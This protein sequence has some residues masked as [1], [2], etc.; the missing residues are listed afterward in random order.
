[1]KR[2][3]AL[4]L[5]LIMT[6][7]L[8]ACGGDKP[9]SSTP[10][11][12]PSNPTSSTP[13]TPDKP[14]EPEKPTEPDKP[15]EP[16]IAYRYQSNES[17]TIFPQ[18]SASSYDEYIIDKISA[19]LYG[20]L[21]VDGKAVLSPVLADGEPIDVNGDGKTW[22]IKVNK[23]AKWENGDPINADTF[24]FTF[25]IALDPK[26]YYTGGTAV[27]DN[28]IK[29]VNA[30]KYHTQGKEGATPVAW[31]E[32]GVK[33]I[34]EYTFQVQVENSVSVLDVMRHLNNKPLMPVHEGLYKKLTA[35]DGT[36]TYG[37]S[38]DTILSCGPYRLTEWVNEALHMFE[39]NEN[40]IRADLVKIDQ[41]KESI[42]K[43]ANTRLQMFENG[44]LDYYVLSTAAREK[45]EDDPRVIATPSRTTTVIE[46]MDQSTKNPI[47]G[48]LNFRMAMYYGLNREELSKLGNFAPNLSTISPTAGGLADGTLYK[49]YA[50]AN[51]TYLGQDKM[52]YDPELAKQYFD[53]ALQETGLKN[54]EVTFLVTE[55]GY[56]KMA[57]Y[58][59]AAWPKMFGEDKI[60]V[61]VDIQTTGV[62]TEIRNTWK[63]NPSAYD[64]CFTG[65]G[66]AIADFNPAVSSRYFNTMQAKRNAPH[67]NDEADAFFVASTSAATPE[68]KYRLAVEY[69]KALQKTM[70]AI[71]V[72][73]GSS[74]CIFS[75]RYVSPIDPENYDINGGWCHMYAD[76]IQ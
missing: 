53:K 27:A 4:I 50:W 31:E 23:N 13:A 40:Y 71:P 28:L 43:D 63:E 67:I 52:G 44:E 45:Y 5:A 58:L 69:E 26:A 12:T 74:Y 8:V 41:I 76:I 9:T 33:K 64:L 49:D 15:A 2:T 30:T 47:L 35:A 17:F 25:Q 72:V 34:D 18:A 54:V 68:E 29:I 65:S 66:P 51:N 38:K 46:V 32:V 3:L 1:M 11:S 61:N 60:K 62:I 39:K 57:E 42:V 56:S 73:Y 20:Y 21:P 48:N 55:G 14:T 10:S 59:Q 36:T 70:T 19:K 7:A 24:I 75:D 16:K 37:T 22:N 6:M